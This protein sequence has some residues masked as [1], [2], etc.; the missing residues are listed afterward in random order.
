MERKGIERFAPLAG[1]LFL[2][3]VIVGIVV[4][5]EEPPDTDESAAKIAEFYKDN[6]SKIMISAALEAW[7]AV[8]LVW[9]AASVRERTVNSAPN[10]GRLAAL[11]FAGGVIAAVGLATDGALQFAA[12]EAADDIPAEGVQTI[13]AIWSSFFFPMIVGVALLT[14]ASGLAAVR[15]GAFNKVLGWIAIV[16]G[17]ISLTPVGFVGAI[18]TVLWI[19]AMGIVLF[20]GQDGGAA[21]PPAA[22][23]APVAPA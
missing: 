6:D 16:L 20:R 11:A 10:A 22:P 13:N 21:P 8:V 1:V 15:H 18:G 12:A 5:G 14:L 23:E 17:V 7:A 4:T 3:I 19:G 9:F 2:L